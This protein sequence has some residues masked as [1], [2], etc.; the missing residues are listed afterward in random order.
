M[1]GEHWGTMVWG[2]PATAVEQVP[3]GPWALLILGFLLGVSAVFARSHRLARV[4]PLFVV[5][6]IPVVSVVAFNVPHVFVN[7]TIADADQVNANFQAVES[8]I[9]DLSDLGRYTVSTGAVSSS[10]ILVSVEHASFSSLCG[11][12]VFQLRGGD[13][14]SCHD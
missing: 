11:D 3:I 14:I 6:L 5:F 4:F 8:E 12:Y 2:M 9:S 7:G 13:E 10:S 1:S